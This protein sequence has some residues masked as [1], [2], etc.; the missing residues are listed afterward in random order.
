[1]LFFA[2]NKQMEKPRTCGG[3]W[4]STYYTIILTIY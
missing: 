1:L 3:L 2:E 4:V